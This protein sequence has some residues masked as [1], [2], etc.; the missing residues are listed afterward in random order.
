MKKPLLITIRGNSGT[1]KTTISKYLRD[2]KGFLL[3]EQDN[4]VWGMR[5]GQTKRFAPAFKDL[6]SCYNNNLKR[7][8]NILIEG[9]FVNLQEK[10]QKNLLQKL[11]DKAEKHNYKVRSFYLF[12][13]DAIAK[14]RMRKRKH[15]VPI[16]AYK[17]RKMD[18]ESQEI[19]NEILIDNSMLTFRQTLNKLLKEI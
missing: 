3:L 14:K 16:N 9:N 19:K 15:V 11:I 5:W 1:G 2:K 18:L 7:G 10:T 6:E 12:T 4:F 17:K 13:T 8:E